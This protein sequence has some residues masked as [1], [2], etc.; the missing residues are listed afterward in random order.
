MRRPRQLRDRVQA[1]VDRVGDAATEGV[2]REDEDE[3]EEDVK[4]LFDG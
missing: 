3:D 1:F 2:P 4:V